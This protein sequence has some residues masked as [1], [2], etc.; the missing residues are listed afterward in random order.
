LEDVDA[1]LLERLRFLH[2]EINYLNHEQELGFVYADYISDTRLRKAIERTLHVAI[3]ICLDIGR[4]LIATEGFRYPS[5]N[6][7][8]FRVLNEV[9]ILPA[10]LLP[11]L[12]EMARFRNLIVHDYAQIN[13]ERVYH[14]LQTRLGDFA[15][16]AQ[17]IG[18]YLEKDH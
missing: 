7:D 2:N 9:E 12:V 5:D 3:E 8:V 10:T 11:A 1:I 6:Q 16:F 13:N 18:V 14:I 17:A 4:R 15:A